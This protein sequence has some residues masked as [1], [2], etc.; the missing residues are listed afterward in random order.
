MATRRFHPE[1]PASFAFSPDNLAWAR[2]TAKPLWR[3]A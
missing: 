3:K 2:E 1:Q